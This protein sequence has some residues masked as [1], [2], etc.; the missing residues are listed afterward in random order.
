MERTREVV[1]TG[2]GVVSPIGVGNDAFWTSLEAGRSGVRELT[3]AE[4]RCNTFRFGAPLAEFESIAPQF[5]VFR[6]V[7]T[8]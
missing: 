1:I 2:T 3:P 4:G 6:V 8:K 5:P 7:T